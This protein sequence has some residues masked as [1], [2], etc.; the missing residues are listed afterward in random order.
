MIIK[1]LWIHQINLK[2]LKIIETLNEYIYM[3][4]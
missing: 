2:I 3:A 4:L 1:I